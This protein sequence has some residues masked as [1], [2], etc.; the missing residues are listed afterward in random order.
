[1]KLKLDTHITYFGFNL[2]DASFTANAQNID[3][4][5]A[6]FFFSI[7]RVSGIFISSNICLLLAPFFYENYTNY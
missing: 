7:D 2:N 6:Q 5:T 1:M 4:A 3:S